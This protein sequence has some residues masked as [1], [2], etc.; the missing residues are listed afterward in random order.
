MLQLMNSYHKVVI[1]IFVWL[2]DL[3]A[4]NKSQCDC[5]QP[6]SVRSVTQLKRSMVNI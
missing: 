3:L 2:S 1:L 5:K 4:S 6:E